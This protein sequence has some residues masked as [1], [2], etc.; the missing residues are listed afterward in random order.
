MHHF[1]H[2]NTLI[3]LKYFVENI[4]KVTKNVFKKM[5]RAFCT[6]FL[7]AK[8]LQENLLFKCSHVLTS[9]PSQKTAILLYHSVL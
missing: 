7:S 5:S 2:Q 9:F 3:R 4:F 6:C 8:T 1:V